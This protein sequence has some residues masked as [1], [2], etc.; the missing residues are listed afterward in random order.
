MIFIHSFN[1]YFFE[2]QVLYIEYKSLTLVSEVNIISSDFLT[3][4]Q[5]WYGVAAQEDCEN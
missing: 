1:K 2:P 4:S 5:S 3:L